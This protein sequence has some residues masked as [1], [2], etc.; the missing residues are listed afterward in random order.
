MVQKK[1]K[2]KRKKYFK[3]D[4]FQ[5]IKKSIAIFLTILVS[6]PQIFLPTITLAVTVS[7][8]PNPV[9]T[10]SCGL[11][12]VLAIDNSGSIDATELDQEKNAFLALVDDLSGTPT[13]FAVISFNTHAVSRLT[14][15]FSANIA[16]VKSAINSITYAYNT[17][18][19]W[20]DALIVAK[21]LLPNESCK[22]NLIVFA[23]D[24]NPTVNNDNFG[25]G[26]ITDGN[27]LNY[28]ITAG[29]D[30][31]STYNTRIV[32]L[33]IGNDVNE[34]N[35]R[36]ISGNESEDHYNVDDFIDLAQ[37]LHD[38]AAGLCGGTITV[39]K[40]VGDGDA[41]NWVAAGAGWEFEIGGQAG[42]VTDENGQTEAV[43]LLTGTGYTVAETQQTGYELANAVCSISNNGQ[44]PLGTLDLDNDQITG[45]DIT[46]D[47]IISCSFYNTLLPYCGDGT[48]DSGEE[49]DD[50]N[51]TDGDGCSATC[52]DE[53][54]PETCGNEE[55]DE[56]EECDNGSA[57]GM[58][59]QPEYGDCTYCSSVCT[60][61]SVQ[62]PYCG[63]NHVDTPYEQCDDGNN[64][65]N[66]G[67]S[68]ACEKE[69]L[70]PVCGN[71]TIEGNE[72]CDDGNTVNGDGCSSSCTTETQS[73]VCGN[74]ILENGEGCDDGNTDDG[75]GCSALC[76]TETTPVDGLCGT[77][78]NKTYPW[79]AAGFDS[80]TFCEIGAADPSD[81]AFPAVGDSVDWT[82][83][84]QNNGADA[85]CSAL[86]DVEPSGCTDPAATNYDPNAVD[87]DGSCQYPQSQT[88]GGST[89]GGGISGDFMP[90][91]GPNSGGGIMPQVAGA[92]IDLDDIQRQIDEIR[93][94]VNDIASQVMKGVLGAATQ[95]STGVCDVELPQGGDYGDNLEMFSFYAKLRAE[96]C[97]PEPTLEIKQKKTE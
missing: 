50:G 42:K 13:E 32:T 59:C 3:S 58:P 69:F 18:T 6:L 47:D 28:A 93:Q 63:D 19:N 15:G 8:I 31:K 78:N 92:S 48:V 26:L 97:L 91:Y 95:V 84:G 87:D 39:S 46:T 89:S 9:L 10:Q 51:N 56:G 80:D 35:L 75:D 55:L 20:Q 72:E 34:E 24:G 52:K 36:K 62:G 94:K 66:D 79:D 90:G 12:L 82:C 33:G 68:S 88:S 40:F 76:Q 43:S 41:A 30:V 44:T 77:A 38:L 17:A 73:P 49:C 85:Q 45:I 4:I 83:L 14:D 5:T 71:G 27:D 70:P 11:D 23:S 2:N 16:T 67:C 86:R 65:D 29:N 37:A 1:I 54:A 96:F 60:V 64:I 53:T 25:T 22:Q 61:A 81:V 57:N 7:P 74:G 21:S